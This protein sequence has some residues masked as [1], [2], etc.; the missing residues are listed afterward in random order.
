M[1]ASQTT[2]DSR[3]STIVKLPRIGAMSRNRV[4][5]M[6]NAMDTHAELSTNSA[7][8]GNASSD[9]QPRCRHVPHANK[10]IT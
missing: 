7:S 3:N 2:G 1:L 10:T 4:D 9:D 6:P 8:A 5:R